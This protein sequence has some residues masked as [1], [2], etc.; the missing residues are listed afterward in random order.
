M[1][2]ISI[3]KRIE[4]A[5]ELRSLTMDELASRIGV[6][7]STIQRYEKG[8]ITTIKL[9]VIDSIAR[10]LKVNPSWI[11]GK[12]DA[13]DVVNDNRTASITIP[14]LGRVAAGIPIDAISE[15]IDREEIPSEMAKSGEYFGLRIKGDS[16]S[17]YIMDG[18]TFIVR[19]QDDAESDEIIIALVNGHDGVCKKLKKLNSGLMLIS[20][21]PQYD[22]MVFDHSEIDTMPVR[23][24]GRVVE[25]RRKM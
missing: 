18:D 1:D 19:R 23:I 7:K 21:N 14:V 17:P 6:A 5:R 3:G 12:T 2:N 4:H 24:L 9:P 8:K 25:V 13:M 15:I 11:I 20:L 16:M 10:E 22:P